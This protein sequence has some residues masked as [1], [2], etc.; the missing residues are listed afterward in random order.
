MRAVELDAG[1][2]T[3]HAILGH[4]CVLRRSF[5][6]AVQYNRRAVEINPNS[7]WNA[8]D[9][10]SI[11]VYTGESEEA[12]TW[13]ARSR[14]I[15]PYFDQAWSWRSAGLACMNL[16]RYA[17]ALSMLSRLRIRTYYYAALN[18]GC[19]AR[20][21]DLHRAKA[22]AHECLSMKPDFSIAHF[23]SKL[24]FKNPADA[25]QLA[26]IPASS[27]SAG[28]MSVTHSASNVIEPAWVGEILHFW[29]DELEAAQWFTKSDA[30]DAQIR[31]RFLALH[32]RV[33]AGGGSVA[34]TQ[35]PLL[36]AVIVLDQFSR[37]CSVA[38]H[39]LSRPILSRASYPEPQ[40]S[41]AST[42]T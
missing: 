40:S 36:A 27:G 22:S 12:L 21:G 5:E 11:L 34:M 13:F 23:M 8:A 6:L 25:D 1:E 18:A 2:S 4:V 3:C 15:D 35:R 39:V 24:P 9:L 10:G 16:G 38:R 37:T 33:V 41:S 26:C 32:R 7:Q 17:D 28:I 20:L 30:I 19:H 29:F 42:R 14:E 31:A